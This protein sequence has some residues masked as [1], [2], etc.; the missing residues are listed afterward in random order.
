MPKGN[1]VLSKKMAMCPGRLV[2]ASG[3]SWVSVH[4]KDIKL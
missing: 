1:E 3:V 4:D 2:L